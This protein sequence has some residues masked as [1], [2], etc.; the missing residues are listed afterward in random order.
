MFCNYLSVN[1]VAGKESR[2]FTGIIECNQ[3]F[4]KFTEKH[5]LDKE[6]DR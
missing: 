1:H 2:R 3:L 5:P 6:K 4:H